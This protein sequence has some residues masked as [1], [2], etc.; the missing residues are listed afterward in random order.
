MSRMF[1]LILSLSC[2]LSQQQLIGSQQVIGSQQDSCC[3]YSRTE[4]DCYKV[5][6]LGCI[7]LGTCIL[8]TK[9]EKAIEWQHYDLQAI[10]QDLQALLQQMKSSHVS[11]HGFAPAPERVLMPDPEPI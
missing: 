2:M 6:C 9:V 11:P 7:A 1:M 5:A 8:A 4:L 3:G 10:H